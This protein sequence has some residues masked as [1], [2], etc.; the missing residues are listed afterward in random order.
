[1]DPQA[2]LGAHGSVLSAIRDA[3]SHSLHTLA[4]FPAGTASM[5]L[6]YTFHPN[7]RPEAR[8]SR[9]T[10]YIRA[11]ASDEETAEIL[12]LLIERG[13]FAQYYKVSCAEG[14][15]M[16]W[17]DLGAACDI[18]RRE[19]AIQPLYSSEHNWKI[20]PVFY[21]NYPFVSNDEN[22][23]LGLDRVLDRMDDPVAIEIAAEPVD[24]SR[25]Q[26]AITRYCARLSEIN[27]SWEGEFQ[28]ID[29]VDF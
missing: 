10:L 25:E 8:Q 21:E 15:D 22:D 5:G 13:P 2:L 11:W 20:P 9:L 14:L 17:D 23:Y 7:R 26:A 4:S 18:V 12:R 29:D 27:R 16:R 19:E 3:A 28:K 24:I 1:M 6:L